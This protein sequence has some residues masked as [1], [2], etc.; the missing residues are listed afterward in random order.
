MH[1]NFLKYFD[2]NGMIASNAQN[3]QVQ[4]SEQVVKHIVRVFLTNQANPD[5]C[6]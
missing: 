1:S 3:R 2:A 5:D 4:I 6:K